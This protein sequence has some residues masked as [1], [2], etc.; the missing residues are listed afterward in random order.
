MAVEKTKPCYICWFFTIS[1]AIVAGTLL[2]NAITAGITHLSFDKYL[3]IPGSN[4]NRDPTVSENKVTT[5][6]LPTVKLSPKKD[7]PTVKLIPKDELSKKDED[8]FIKVLPDKSLPRMSRPKEEMPG[9]QTT[10]DICNFWKKEY[11]KEDTKQNAT[12][13][14]AACNRLK[15]YQ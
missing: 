12:Y 6:E 4:E 7:I 10:L 14:E 9:Y 1:L 13:M 5:K 8:A 2:S 11:K 3:N 15:T